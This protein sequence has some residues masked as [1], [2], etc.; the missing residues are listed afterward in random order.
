MTS[1]LRIAA[2]CTLLVC[3]FSAA[4]VVYPAL[5]LPTLLA[6]TGLDSYIVSC[7]DEASTDKLLSSDGG[8]A[9]TASGGPIV[10]D[11]LLCG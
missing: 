2:L 11:L 9:K 3:S 6:V 4:V 1:G 8:H 10:T 7:V 5:L